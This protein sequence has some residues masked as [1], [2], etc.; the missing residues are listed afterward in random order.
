MSTVRSR[1]V[2]FHQY[3]E[4]ADVLRE[5]HV[6]VPTPPAGR[7]RVRV[8]A[9][10]LNPA[11]WELCRGFMAADLPRGVGFEVSG[12]VDAVGELVEGVEVGDLVFGMSDFIREPSAGLADVAILQSWALVP[13]GLGAIQASVLPMAVQTAA[14]SLEAMGV[15][16]GST[17]LIHG[18]GST[19]GFAAVQIA[20][21]MGA[22]VIAT[23]GSTYAGDLAGFG[24]AV[25][26]YG[27]GMVE[28][29][30]ELA[31]GPVDHVLD[32]PPPNAGSLPGLIQIAGDPDRVVTISNHDEARRLGAHVNLDIIKDPTPFEQLLPQYAEL[33]AAGQF[34]IPVARTFAFG[35][36]RDAVAL[37]MSGH[38]RGK[39]VLT[40][41]E[42]PPTQEQRVGD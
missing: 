35:D 4:P 42:D 31:A 25:T 41:Q 28:R 23:A 5:D 8:L 16:P 39:L 24:A 12:T 27:D 29:V 33:A 11:D 13:E 1:A 38:P 34:R 6:D 7:V 32:T 26:P 20:T 10:G 40:P 30:R 2:R 17:V 3:G 36:W 18:A 9:V 19:V 14:W 15:R 21:R 22:R 37:S